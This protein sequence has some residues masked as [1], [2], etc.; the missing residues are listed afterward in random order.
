MHVHDNGVWEPS[1][2][3]QDVCRVRALRASTPVGREP[4]ESAA[5]AIQ[6]RAT[7]LEGSLDLD[8]LAFSSGMQRVPSSL[9]I[10]L[11]LPPRLRC[12]G[13]RPHRLLRCVGPARVRALADS[14]VD[15]VR[16]PAPGAH[17]EAVP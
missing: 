9:S 10:E 12:D 11:R 6:P 13:P 7:L 2:A 16:G 4:A 15:S 3:L 17:A 14:H 1:F 8:L 5:V